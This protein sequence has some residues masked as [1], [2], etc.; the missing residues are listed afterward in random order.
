[1]GA[2]LTVSESQ[3][4]TATRVTT[5]NNNTD[6]PTVSESQDNTTEVRVTQEVTTVKDTADTTDVSQP[7]DT[8]EELVTQE[9]DTSKDAESSIVK[10]NMYNKLVY[11]ALFFLNV[12]KNL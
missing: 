9:E 1:M 7:E 10:K 6:Q 11:I 5:A 2:Q 8:E 3:G 4:N 12:N